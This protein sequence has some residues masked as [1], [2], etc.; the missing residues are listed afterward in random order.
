ME[1]IQFETFP[2]GERDGVE[3]FRFRF[4]DADAFKD[5]TLNEADVPNVVCE[6]LQVQT[7]FKT[8]G[9]VLGLRRV[10]VDSI[11]Q[12]HSD[13]EEC[14]FG[15][16]DEFVKQVEPPPTWRVI[17]EALRNPLIGLPH[18][19]EE[20]ENKYCPHPPTNDGTHT[21]CPSLRINCLLPH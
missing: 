16:L 15:A 10:T 4:A 12:Q 1:C 20:I 17:L 18:L 9:R 7:K 8:F 14:L 19:A 21:L 5:R 13:P 2:T 11:H 3:F 6:I